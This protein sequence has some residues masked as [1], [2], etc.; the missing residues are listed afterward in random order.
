M[1]DAMAQGVR[2][3]LAASG[4]RPERW[5]PASWLERLTHADSPGPTWVAP[6][7]VTG[8]GGRVIVCETVPPKDTFLTSQKCFKMQLGWN[9]MEW[10]IFTNQ[11]KL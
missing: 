2:E 6:N 9:Q 5:A 8:R 11:Q 1:R 3:D 7:E 10:P 4:V